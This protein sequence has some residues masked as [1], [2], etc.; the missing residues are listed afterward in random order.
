MRLN[1]LVFIHFLIF[2]QNLHGA[3]L[4]P[5]TEW[6]LL[7]TAHFEVIYDARNHSIAAEYAAQAERAHTI[8]AP[9]FPVLP[10]QK[11]I[12]TIVD[13]TDLANG[14]ATSF[15][16]P[17]ITIFPVLPTYLDSISHYDNWSQ[18][19][20]LHEYTHILSMEESNGITAPLRFIFGSI[21]RPNALMPRWYLEG[22]AVELES[23]YT[24][25]GRLRSPFY[26]AVTRALIKDGLWRS[27]SI[28]QANESIPTWPY[29]MRPY[30][31]GSLLLHEIA[32]RKGPKEMVALNSR[33]AG[34]IPFFING[35][36]EDL[37]GLDYADL[38]ESVRDKYDRGA[39]AQLEEIE[40]AGSPP[41]Q[42]LSEKNNLGIGPQISS[43]G[44]KL[45]YIAQNNDGDSE[46]R[47]MKRDSTAVHFT[48]NSTILTTGKRINK[49]SWF[50]DSKTV[51]YDAVA[52]AGLYYEFSDLHVLDTETVEDTRITENFRAQEPTVDRSGKNIAFVQLTLAKT[53]ISIVDREGKN[54]RNL[55]QASQQVRLSRPAFLNSNEIIFSEKL[56][57]GKEY[58]RIVNVET[59]SIRT[60]LESFEPAQAPQV[61]D[62]GLVFVSEKTGIAN[63]YLANKNLTDAKAITNSPTKIL[64]GTLD[65]KNSDIYLSQLSGTGSQIYRQ[66]LASNALNPPTIRN[67]A[68]SAWS[69]FKEPAAVTTAVDKEYKPLTY[70]WPQYWLPLF[71]LVP[72]GVYLSASTGAADPLGLHA[73]SLD[74]T[75]DSLSQKAGAS[76]GY[77][78]NMGATT[79][80]LGAFYEPVYYYSLKISTT[81][82]GGSAALSFP[83]T[84]NSTKWRGVTRWGYISQEFSGQ[85]LC[86]EGE[87]PSSICTQSGPAVGVRFDNAT[88]KN[89]MISPE[90][91]GSAYLEHQQN[92]AGIGNTSFGRTRF[93]GTYYFSKWLPQRNA[94]MFRTNSVWSPS[95]RNIL[96]G[97][98]GGGDY[99]FTFI[100]PQFTVRGYPVGNFLGWSL[101]TATIEYRFPIGTVYKGWDTKPFFLRR[102]HAG[103]F[104]DAI[105]ADG[106]YYNKTIKNLKATAL[107][108]IFYGVGT[109]F[110]SDVT[111]AYHVPATFRLG[112][113]YGM[114]EEAYGGF[115]PFIGLTVPK[116]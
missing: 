82:S 70:L 15:P 55:Y 67:A 73:I 106:A 84:Y 43:D 59:K 68:T 66:K 36:I 28:A 21:V 86:K 33:Y 5:D 75:Y 114:N 69:E 38:L 78:R 23:R 74:A 44:K 64:M 60:V 8:L 61:T 31:W 2:S 101:A 85:T 91:G 6:K 76:A 105:A 40:K 46:L 1:A 53:N 20:I 17:T 13:W 57:S 103:I 104:A 32:E 37:L 95:N 4:N 51:V 47:L 29:G 63:L 45:L 58:F 62:A 88:I 94:I 108:N 100:D 34:R 3:A 27:D 12:I 22:L 9:I 81:T 24:R 42:P 25:Y 83:L 110:R 16:R 11:T 10:S 92:L 72:D 96:L 39:K 113:F 18:Q 77:A 87:P 19:I 14:M 35:P 97:S 116:F 79:F 50:P 41:L 71:S 49:A 115:T 90:S 98:S 99:S 65:S 54:W 26:Q 80:S 56:M 89:S 52:P 30:F 93:N 102:W 111:L 109:E 112:L 48:G 107:G 7:E